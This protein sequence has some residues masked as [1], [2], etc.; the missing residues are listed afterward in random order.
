MDEPELSPLEIVAIEAM[1]DPFCPI[2]TNG[3][4]YLPSQCLPECHICE[5]LLLK[6]RKET[7]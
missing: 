1:L 5:S 3:G 7:A 4:N 2:A 6:Q